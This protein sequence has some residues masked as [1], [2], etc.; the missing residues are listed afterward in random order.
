MKS[1]GNTSVEDKPR[2]E[3]LSPVTSDAY[4]GGYMRFTRTDD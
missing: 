4:F 1:K 2:V 3:T